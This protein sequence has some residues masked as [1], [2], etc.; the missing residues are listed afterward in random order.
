MLVAVLA[1]GLA[2]LALATAALGSALVQAQGAAWTAQAQRARAAARAGVVLL[3]A[4]LAERVAGGGRL[5]DEAPEL[6]VGHALEIRVLSYRPIDDH[7]VE[8][9]LEGRSGT[10]TL[11]AGAL[12]RYR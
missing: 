2:L 7:A 12:L 1:S 8:V 9:E 3:D 5:P 6:P 10:A 4:T 11:R